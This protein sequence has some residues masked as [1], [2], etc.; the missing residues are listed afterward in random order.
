MS[1]Q[2][3]VCT[4]CGGKI[5]VDDIDLNGFGECEFCHTSYK[6]I[7][8]ITIDGLP[9]AKTLYIAATHSIEDGNYEK[10]VKQ[11]KEIIKIK[12]NCHESWWAL[13][14]CHNY[15][16]QYYEYKDK[17]GNSGPITKA[18]IMSNSINKFAN[19]AIEYAPKDISE[20]YKQNIKE[21][22]DFIEA[23]TRGDFDQK[24]KGKSGC[25][26]A[27]A[28]YGSYECHQVMKLREYR[29]NTLAKNAAGRFFI[30]IYY[31]ISP[32][33]LWIFERNKNVTFTIRKV[34]DHFVKTRL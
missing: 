28:V 31:T 24:Q 20:Q 16:D 21:S 1:L 17:Y 12:P 27:T 15:F 26:I 25:Y 9:T 30:R 5:D 8:V 7:D 32:H 3:A 19:R 22:V 11:L 4:S 18:Q 10:A 14:V 13:Y 2:P 23:V 6:V 33:L 34:L 29:D